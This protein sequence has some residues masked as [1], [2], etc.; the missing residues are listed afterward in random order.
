MAG[1]VPTKAPVAG[2]A[3]GLS[4]MEITTV[5]TDIQGLRS[6][7]Y[8]L[9]LCTVMGLRPSNDIKI[10]GHRNGR[11]VQAKKARF[12]LDVIEAPFQV[13]RLRIGSNCPEN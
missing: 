4:Q 8:G 13:V 1:G 5:L 6:L 2:I 3:K 11:S 12:E 7:R 9:L 10:Q